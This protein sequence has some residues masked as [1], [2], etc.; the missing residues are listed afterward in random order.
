MARTPDNK[1]IADLKKDLE[2][3]K[4]LGVDKKLI[5]KVE[6]IIAEQEKA[7]EKKVAAIVKSVTTK[8]KETPKQENIDQRLLELLGLEDYE[9]ELDYDQYITLI[10][11]KL[12]ASR[13][14]DAGKVSQ[15]GDQELLIKELR[16]AQKSSGSFKVKN[17]RPKKKTVTASGFVGKKSTTTPSSKPKR[18]QTNKLYPLDKQTPQKKSRQN[19]RRTLKRN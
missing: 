15:E 1:S 7:E 3:M 16:R 6:K 17:T 2:E 11:E 4:K 8:K 10:K 12:A 5:D 14:V 9:A 19:Y 13:M 18:V